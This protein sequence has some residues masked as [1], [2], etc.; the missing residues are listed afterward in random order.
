MKKLLFLTCLLS[1]SVFAQVTT[2]KFESIDIRTCH[3]EMMGCAPTLKING[4]SILLDQETVSDELYE[5]IRQ[6]N[7]AIINIKDIEGFVAKETGHFPNPMA[8]FE[9]FKVVI[10]D[11]DA[12]LNTCNFDLMGCTTRITALD[13]Q[14]TVDLENVPFELY[15]R[16]GVDVS[17]TVKGY[18]AIEDGHMPNPMVEQKVFKVI[19]IKENDI[20]ELDGFRGINN[21]RINNREEFRFDGATPEVL[22]IEVK[23]Q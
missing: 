9:V 4:K 11:A 13:E 19:E 5:K 1:I 17:V 10:N 23:G 14:L 3:E 16:D 22:R 8:E 21:S 15:A 6:A 18:Y 2:E 12:K 7:G 20:I